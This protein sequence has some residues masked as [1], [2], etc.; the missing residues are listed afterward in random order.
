MEPTGTFRKT[1][2]KPSQN[3]NRLPRR[4]MLAQEEEEEEESASSGGGGGE[5]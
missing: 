2:G 4:R 1:L 3:V 5:C